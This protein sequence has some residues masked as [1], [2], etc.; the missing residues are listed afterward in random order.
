MGN[1]FVKRYLFKSLMIISLILSILF[2]YINHMNFIDVALKF[3]VMNIPNIAYSILRIAGG[4]FIPAVFL[5]PSAFEYGRIRLAKAG[6]ITYGICHLIT[7]SWIIYFFATQPPADFFNYDKVY[8][9]L[10][11]G[12]FIYQ[13]TMWDTW[14]NMSI[15][16]TLI[17][18]ILAIYTGLNFDKDKD[19]VRLLTI[20]L[21]ALRII[22]PFLNDIILGGRLYT[23][24][25]IANN[26]LDLASQL[27]FTVAI[28]V[29]SLENSTWIE[30]VWD[31]LVFP[32]NS[33]EESE[34]IE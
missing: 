5:V 33:D 26:Y 2:F 4:L 24:Y 23:E 17:F 10:Y 25:W 16:F 28:F 18:G 15:V 29:A 14:N 30:F 7:L 19:T 11:T 1:Y 22:L 32:E 34:N 6:F 21:L 31:Q 8:N 12:G 3:G 20:I 13:F 9:F 27:C